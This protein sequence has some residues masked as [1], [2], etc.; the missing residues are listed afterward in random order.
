METYKEL[1]LHSSGW[2]VFSLPLELAL[3]FDLPDEIIEHPLLSTL[4]MAAAFHIAFV[5]DIFSF[6]KELSDGDLMNL[7]PVLLWHNLGSGQHIVLLQTVEPLVQKTVLQA[8][9][10]V[11]ELEEECVWLMAKIRSA[12]RGGNGEFGVLA[13]EEAA[14]AVEMYLDGVSDW[15]SGNLQWHRISKRYVDSNINNPSISIGIKSTIHKNPSI[16]V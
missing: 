7:V 1:R 4:K 14:V 13:D 2:Y 15:L 8:L 3:G 5:N 10:L 11:R 9:G 6:R 16:S 12:T